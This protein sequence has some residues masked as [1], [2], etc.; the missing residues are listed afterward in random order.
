[1]P[2]F[3]GPVEIAQFPGGASNLTYR[4]R[5]AEREWVLRRPPFGTRARSAHDMGREY[6]ILSRIHEAFPYAPKPV[7][8]C[9]DT[10]RWARSS[11]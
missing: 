11:T 4:V 2:G 1:L 7:L 3:T 5:A 10:R 6:R 9:A 8:F